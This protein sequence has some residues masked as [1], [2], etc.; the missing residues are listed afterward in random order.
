MQ[1]VIIHFSNEISVIRTGRASASKLYNVKVDYYGTVQPLKNISHISAPE[2][3]MII[4]TPFDPS[5]LE[6]IEAALI[7]SAGGTK[8][9][10]IT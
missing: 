8:S 2:P 7:S 5:S 1:K 6:M 10:S 4:V 3:Q 9:V